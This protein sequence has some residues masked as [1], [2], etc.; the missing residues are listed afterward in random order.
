ML[1]LN[2]SYTGSYWPEPDTLF[3]VQC[4]RRAVLIIYGYDW[5]VFQAMWLSERIFDR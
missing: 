1:S 2:S 4:N 5:S 3:S